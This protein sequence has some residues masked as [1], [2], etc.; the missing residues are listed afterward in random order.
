MFA[1]NGHRKSLIKIS[2]PHSVR[3]PLTLS[4]CC[5]PTLAGISDTEPAGVY[6]VADKMV[7]RPA[8]HTCSP[9]T[10]VSL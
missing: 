1:E 5:L 8:E 2:T 3:H 7:H 9:M 4:G 10:E 6:S